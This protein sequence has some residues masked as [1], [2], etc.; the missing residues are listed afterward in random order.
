VI[1]IAGE[2]PVR[3]RLAPQH[4][5][6]DLH[7]RNLRTLGLDGFDAGDQVNRLVRDEISVQVTADVVGA[8]AVAVAII[9]GDQRTQ[10]ARIARLGRRLG[11]VDQRA[12]L[13]FGRA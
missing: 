7:A 1:N 2:I 3:I 8:A 9:S 5:D 13:V 12:D 6:G 10:G 11:L 4:P